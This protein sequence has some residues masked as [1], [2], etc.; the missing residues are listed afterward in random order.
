MILNFASKLLRT[1]IPRYSVTFFKNA[2]EACSD[3]KDGATLLVGGFGLAGIPEHCF[4]AL[5]HSKV[6][7]LT[8]VSNTGGI[9]DW[10]IG[11]L[12]QGR[13]VKRM[14]C[15]YLGDNPLFES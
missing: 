12:L 3:I 6:Q 8:M 1:Q 2:Q 5:V 4:S 14:I 11:L 7:D 13:Q 10:G 9:P 15:S